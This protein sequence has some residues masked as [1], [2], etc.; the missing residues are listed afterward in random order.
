MAV[1]GDEG[2]LRVGQAEGSAEVVAGLMRVAAFE[3]WPG[4]KT[5]LSFGERCLDPYDG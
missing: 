2:A 4:Q 3:E 1:S 5:G